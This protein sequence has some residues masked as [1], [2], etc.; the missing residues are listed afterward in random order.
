V[1]IKKYVYISISTVSVRTNCP[2]SGKVSLLLTSPRT[3]GCW[4]HCLYC[5]TGYVNTDDWRFSRWTRLGRSQEGTPT[6]TVSSQQV[7]GGRNIFR[8]PLLQ[9]KNTNWPRY[10]S[11]RY[12]PFN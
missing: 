10:L 5:C 4:R 9:K 7:F 2:L 1:Q 12:S 8:L 11:P 3:K 6:I